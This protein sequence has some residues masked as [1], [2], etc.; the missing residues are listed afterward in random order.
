M[1]KIQHKQVPHLTRDISWRVWETN[2]EYRDNKHLW[3]IIDMGDPVVLMSKNHTTKQYEPVG[4]YDREHAQK[5]IKGNT[6]K[7]HLLAV[8]PIKLKTKSETPK[9]RIKPIKINLSW[10]KKLSHDGKVMVTVAIITL[11]TMI[12]IGVVTLILM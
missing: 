10:Y 8:D 11:I 2:S 12:I 1:P 9:T 3:N 6:D 5:I 4:T 7:Y